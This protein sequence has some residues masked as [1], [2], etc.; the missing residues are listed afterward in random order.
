MQRNIRTS[1]GSAITVIALTLA[2]GGIMGSTFRTTPFTL[3]SQ[4]RESQTRKLLNDGFAP[5]V[6][7]AAPAVVNISSSK[8]VKTN[9]DPGLP[10]G[11]LQPFF[12]Q[13]ADGR[14]G[15]QQ[16][17]RERSLGSGVIVNSTGYVLT[18]NHIVEDATEVTVSLSDDRE[19]AGRV[20]GADP[21][22]D[23]ALLKI[24]AEG[25]PT[26]PF[27][28]SSKVEV[29]DL[30]LA[31][32]NPFGLGRSV[33][34]G[35]V[36]AMGR[37][38]LGI[39]DYEDFIQTDAS[40]NPGSSGGALTNV[41]GELIGVNTAIL[42]PDG[43]S[44]GIGFAVPSNMVRE[45]MNQIL[46]TG[47]VSRGFMGVLLQDITPEI[48]QAMKLGKTRG[49]LVGDVATDTPAS[50]AGIQPGD[51][52]VAADGKPVAARRELQLLIA[53]KTPGSGISLKVRRDGALRDVTL[54]LAETPQD[55]KTQSEETASA[56]AEDTSSRLGIAVS[57][58][59]PQIRH[60]LEIPATV[61]GVIVAEVDEG[62]A[63]A[64]AGILPGDVI[65]ELN[66][67]PVGT[68]DEFEEAVATA[69][70][71]VL[72]LRVSREGRSQFVAIK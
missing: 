60:K 30:A 32:G 40:I 7:K 63:A 20:V 59:T 51:V 17:R 28:D 65:Q 5:V 12:G 39:E 33:T 9:A 71:D 66:R 62:R 68:A 35:I 67:K 64:E 11:V 1:I 4:S 8:L 41:R 3:L 25:L 72:L 45:V 61:K 36:S 54:T 24:N 27:A 29:G 15:P 13:D 49:A 19:F 38:G 70:P 42:S 34:M 16:E 22:T 23:I 69:G 26:I 50:R 58:L 48:A 2:L 57:D 10:D 53:S 55:A 52:I 37:G 21:G 6:Q 44:L 47:R 14:L 31:I 43:L 56:P 46:R 18:N